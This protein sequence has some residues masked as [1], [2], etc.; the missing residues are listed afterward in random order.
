MNPPLQE[1]T[2]HQAGFPSDPRTAI[3]PWQNAE[4]EPIRRTQYRPVNSLH[5]LTGPDFNTATQA[6]IWL[7]HRPERGWTWEAV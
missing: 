2:P 1:S 7:I 4:I 5:G 6:A 3:K